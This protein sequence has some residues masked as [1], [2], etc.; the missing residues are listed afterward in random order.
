MTQRLLV[1]NKKGNDHHF[2][3]R[4][5]HVEA[6]AVLLS[7]PEIAAGMNYKTAMLLLPFSFLH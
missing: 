5:I 4:L 1:D 3:S 2:E 7:L 6:G